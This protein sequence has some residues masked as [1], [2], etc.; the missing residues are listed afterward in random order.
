MEPIKKIINTPTQIDQ[1][2]KYLDKFFTKA[3]NSGHLPYF[4]IG[5]ED[6]R[7]SPQNSKEHAMIGDIRKMAVIK[8]P[9]KKIIMSN[10]SFEECKA[11]LL[12]WFVKEK[13]SQSEKLPRPIDKIMCPIYGEY[14]SIRPSIKDLGKKLTCEFIEFLYSVGSESGVKWSEPSLACYA[15]YREANR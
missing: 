15:E 2:F 8:I 3:L 14:V 6:Q 1:A 13:E 4:E 5:L 11:L 9:G 7:S 10:Y 12:I